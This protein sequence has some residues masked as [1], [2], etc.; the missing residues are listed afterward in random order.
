MFVLA[1][2]AGKLGHEPGVAD[3]FGQDIGIEEVFL[4]ELAQRCGELVLALDQQGSVRNRQ[5]KRSAEQSRHREPVCDA[6]DHGS[7]GAGLHVT[8]ENPMG[9]RHSYSDEDKRHSGKKCGS[10][11]ARGNQAAHPHLDRLAC[12][13]GHR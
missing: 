5:A 4:H 3:P 9:A 11:P 2:P 1:Q 7:L 8:K 6:S 10:P 12:E 13:P